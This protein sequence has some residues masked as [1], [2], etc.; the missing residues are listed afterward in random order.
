[1]GEPGRGPDAGAVADRPAAS[2]RGGG[3]TSACVAVLAWLVWPDGCP[4]VA[5]PPSP[6]PA[7]LLAESH[8]AGYDRAAYVG[9]LP[10]DRAGA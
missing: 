2:R 8:L 1:M 5:A 4:W 7:A 9:A 3:R 10:L 6:V